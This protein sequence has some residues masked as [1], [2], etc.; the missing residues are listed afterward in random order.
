MESLIPIVGILVPFA[1]LFGIVY[2]VYI[3]RHRE[4][5]DLIAKGMTAEAFRAPGDPLNSLK[6]GLVMLG[7]GFGL[8]GGYVLEASTSMEAP[9]PYFIMVAIFGGLALVVFYYR[10]GRV[11]GEQ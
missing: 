10:F 8:V 2:I 5:M 6:L 3:T 9:L 11:R 1:T 4:R 7:V